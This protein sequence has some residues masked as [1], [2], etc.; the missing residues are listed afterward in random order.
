MNKITNLKI[1][2]PP[3]AFTLKLL[4]LDKVC[5]APRSLTEKKHQDPI[6]LSPCSY[7]ISKSVSNLMVSLMQP[8]KFPQG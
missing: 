4:H 6:R 2:E 7:K 8:Q 1:W 5:Q 3:E